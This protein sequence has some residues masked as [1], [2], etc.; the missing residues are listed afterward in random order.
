MMPIP[1]DV[2]PGSNSEDALTALLD[3]LKTLQAEG[4]MGPASQGLPPQNPFEEP[5]TP[6]RGAMQ[7]K[8][9]E[10]TDPLQGLKYALRTREIPAM[11]AQAANL[12]N[13][14]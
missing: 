13:V 2:Q 8:N 12:G 9:A 11:A 7:V 5:M 1:N 3:F 14:Q 10:Q 4:E 6:E